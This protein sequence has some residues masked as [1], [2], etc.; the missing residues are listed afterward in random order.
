MTSALYK[1]MCIIFSADQDEMW[2]AVESR[3][4]ETYTCFILT[5]FSLNAMLTAE[6]ESTIVNHFQ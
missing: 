3:F 2:Y 1:V 5:N 6:A 4:Y